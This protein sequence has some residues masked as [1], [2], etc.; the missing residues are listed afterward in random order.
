MQ[1]S[2]SS[3]PKDSLAERAIHLNERGVELFLQGK[4]SQGSGKVKQALAHDPNNPN[5][6]YNLAGL[7][8]ADGRADLALPVMRKVIFLKPDELAFQD[9]YAESCIATRELDSAIRAY[10]RIEQE[11]SSYNE[12]LLKLSALYAMRER[13]TKAEQTIR[14]AHAHL[15]DNPKVLT[16][17]GAILV[18]RGKYAEAIPILKQ[19]QHIEESAENA[20]A[21]G[22][23]YEFIGDVQKAIR[24]YNRALELGTQDDDGLR[25]HLDE[26][27][28][29]LPM[30]SR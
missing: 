21:L 28:G 8:L 13:W 3:E 14:R 25:K 17:F 24:E 6:L 26:M 12:V 16:N 10:E 23:S 30:Q 11:D 18:A 5:V 27:L 20:V 2:S 19:S 1:D 29:S 15:G 9:R 4:R 22:M 7:Y